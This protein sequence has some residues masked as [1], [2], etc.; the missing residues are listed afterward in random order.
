MSVA[1]ATVCG[2]HEVAARRSLC[3]LI[4]CV[5]CWGILLAI[6]GR[7]VGWG[8]TGELSGLCSLT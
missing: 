2:L 3:L 6:S 1:L 8:T 4:H 5:H 7:I